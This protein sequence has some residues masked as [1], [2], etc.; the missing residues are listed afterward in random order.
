VADLASGMGWS[1]IVI[2]RAYPNARMNGLDLDSG[3]IAD[4]RHN[5]AAESLS[6]R[7]SFTVGDAAAA[8]LSGRF[9]L[10]TI[11][12]SFHD[13]SRPV[14]VLRRVRDLLADGGSVILIDEKVED[15][16][17]APASDL[18][19]YHY[20][21]SIVSCLP[22]AMGDPE[23]AH[24]RG[25]GHRHPSPLRDRGGFR[26]GRRAAHLDGDLALLQA[27]FVTGVAA[28]CAAA[29]CGPA[30]PPGRWCGRPGRW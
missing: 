9:D 4:A 11:L 15:E 21:W 19:R 13:V 29:T 12:E 24:R 1:S 6:D 20:G 8:G 28:T 17:T 16:F 26:G 10:V 22:D 30:A 3:T 23:T 27:L 14:E 5:A 2:A 25:H 7:V 18:E